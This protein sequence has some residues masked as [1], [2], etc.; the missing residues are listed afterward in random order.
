[1]SVVA[2]T[3]DHP[4]HRFLVRSLYDAG[5]LSAWVKEV[6]EEFVPAQP[7]ALSNEISSLAKLHF[8]LRQKAELSFF[9][10]QQ[11]SSIRTLAVFGST[12][13][14]DE[15]IKFI[16]SSHPK[17]VLTYGCSRMEANLINRLRCP[18]W[19]C[20]GCLSPDY[21]GVMTHFWPSYMLEPQMTGMTLHQVTPD[22]DGGRIVHQKG[23]SLRRG[24]GLHML[25][26]RTTRDFFDEV[27]P[28]ISSCVDKSCFPAG[29]PQ[30]RKGKIW[31]KSDWRPEHLRLIYGLFND[32]IVDEY[33]S[34]KLPNTEPTLIS[35]FK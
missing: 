18:I 9:D 19:N 21:K 8:K 31:L 5:F 34:R 33:L 4:R 3:G 20:H 28:L 17:L 7:K 22:L 2:I 24:D 25:A 13:N 1:M 32:K 10:D 35:V 26:A 23:A 29:L 12:L 30:K 15:T 11:M 16:E 14:G 27:I 6:R